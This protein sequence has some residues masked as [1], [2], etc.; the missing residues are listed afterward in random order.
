[1]T[2]ENLLTKYREIHFDSSKWPIMILAPTDRVTDASVEAFLVNYFEL[3][4]AKKERF[5]LIVDLRRKTNLSYKRR[6]YITNTLN[7]NKEFAE[8][9]NA[10]T[11]LIVN[12]AVVRGIMMSV[13]WLF[14]P[15]HPTDVFNTMEQA[16]PWANSCLRPAI[17]LIRSEQEA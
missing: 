5:A 6:K 14:S 17:R 2:Q 12:S 9:Y 16:L 15:K 4:K 11:A 10:G 13:F 3:V 8:K 1:M 7:E